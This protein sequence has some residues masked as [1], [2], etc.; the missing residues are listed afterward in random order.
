MREE[1]MTSAWIRLHRY[2]LFVFFGVGLGCGSPPSSLSSSPTGGVTA[3]RSALTSEVVV[4]LLDGWGDPIADHPIDALDENGGSVDTAVTDGNGQV[5]FFVEEP[6]TYYFRAVYQGAYFDSAACAAPS[7]ASSTVQIMKPV[8]VSVT[9]GYGAAIAD[10]NIT[11]I[12]SEGNQ[13][14]WLTT[15]S[16]GVA[17]VYVPSGAYFFRVVAGNMY[18]DSAATASCEIPGCVSASIAVTSVRVTVT[19]TDGKPAEGVTVAAVD[20]FE[21]NWSATDAQGRA[22]TFVPAGAFKFRVVANGEYYESGPDGHCVVSGCQS[23]SISVPACT[24]RPDGTT[25]NDGA[26]CTQSE[27]CHAGSCQ[28]SSAAPPILN[29]A[30]EH[31]GQMGGNFAIPSDVNA[32]GQTVGGATTASGQSHAFSRNPGGPMVDLGSQ[33]GLP[34]P[35][36][37]N[38]INDA[39]TVVG[40]MTQPDGSH[41]FRYNPSTGLEDLGLGGD[42]SSFTD[43][44]VYEGSYGRDVNGQGQVAGDYTDGGMLRGFRYTDGVGFEDIGSLDVGMT[45]AW[46][47]GNSGTVVGTSW[48]PGTPATNDVRRFGHAVLFQD[49]IS[50]LVD[51]NGLIDPLAGWTLH[52]AIDIAGDFVVG[53]G[54]RN[55]VLR[56]FRL[57]L[58]TG[59][60][61]DI[62]AGWEGRSFGNGVNI[63][64]DVVGWGYRDAAEAQQ[65]GF[66]YSDRF[67]FKNLND[68]INAN[69]WDVRTTSAI[70]NAGDIVGW[71]YLAGNVSAFHVR[72]PQGQAATCQARDVCGGGDGDTICLYSDGVVETSPGHFVAVLGFD[73]SSAASV[74][75]TVN[76]VRLDG[77]LV[78]NPQPAPPPFLLPGTHAGAFLPT[79]ETG[80]TISW[81]INGETVSASAASPRLQPVALPGGGVGV[82]IGGETID[83]AA[84]PQDAVTPRLDGICQLTAGQY[85]AVF[86]YDNIASQNVRLQHGTADNIV[87]VGDVVSANPTPAP[88]SWFLPGTHLGAFLPTFSSGQSVTWT[89]GGT[90]LTA[91]ATSTLLT[92]QRPV[93]GSNALI[94]T[95]QTPDGPTAVWIR[96][97]VP[98]QL[99][100]AIVGPDPTTPGATVGTLDGQLNVS[101]DGAA[102]YHVPIWVPDAPLVPNLALDYNSRNDE[103]FTGVGFSLTG[104]GEITRCRAAYA[105]DPPLRPESGVNFTDTDHLCLDGRILIPTSGTPWT[106]GAKFRPDNDPFTQVDQ[107]GSGEISY[108]EVSRR[109]GTIETYGQ[110]TDSVAGV[111]PAGIPRF[112]WGLNRRV[113]RSGNLVEYKYF[114]PTPAA[115]AIADRAPEGV[116]FGARSGQTQPYTVAFSYEAAANRGGYLSGYAR[117][118][119]RLLN[120]ITVS[121]PTLTTGGRSNDRVYKIAYDTPS[122][123]G[124]KLIKTIQ[125]CDNRDVSVATCMPPTTFTW[126]H[127][128]MRF[129][130]VGVSFGPGI[131]PLGSFAQHYYLLV[132]GDVN[133]DG[134]DDI[135][136]RGLGGFDDPPSATANQVVVYYR[137]SDG[138]GFGPVQMVPESAITPGDAWPTYARESLLFKDVLIA[139]VDMDGAADIKVGEDQRFR[140]ITGN[141]SVAAGDGAADFNGDGLPDYMNANSA[142]QYQNEQPVPNVPISVVPN[143]MFGAGT[144]PASYTFYGYGAFPPVGD[145]DG[146]GSVDLVLPMGH[147]AGVGLP[148]GV[149]TGL[150]DHPHGGAK[151]TVLVDVN[152]DGLPDALAFYESRAQL[153]AG[154]DNENP[155]LNINT[156]FRTGGGGFIPG[157]GLSRPDSGYITW[158]RTIDQNECVSFLPTG[159]HCNEPYRIIGTDPGLRVADF[160]GD[161]RE[162]IISFA[163]NFDSGVNGGIYQSTEAGSTNYSDTPA[164]L[165]IARGNSFIAQGPTTDTGR[166][167]L[168]GAPMGRGVGAN[169]FNR[170]LD[171]NGDGLPDLISRQRNSSLGL[172]L[173][174]HEGKKPD[175]LTSVTNGLGAT[176]EI[177]YDHLGNKE[178]GVYTRMPPGSCAYPQYCVTKGVWV[179]SKLR[180]DTGGAVGGTVFADTTFKYRDARTDVQGLGWIGFASMETTDQVTGKITDTTYGDAFIRFTAGGVSSYPRALLPTNVIETWPLDATQALRRTHDRAYTVGPAGEVLLA[181]S[182]E[183]EQELTSSGYATKT[184]RTLLRPEPDAYDAYGNPLHETER[185]EQSDSPQT[186]LHDV[187]LRTT[188]WTYDNDAQSW[189]LGLKRTETTTLQTFGADAE[190]VVRRLAWDYKP[191]T[192]LIAHGMREPNGAADVRLTTTFE[193]NSR[194]LVTRVIREDASGQR[195]VTDIGYD[196]FVGHLAETATQAG[197]TITQRRHPT[198]GVLVRAEDPNGAGASFVYD[199]FGRPKK[200]L[201]DAAGT[202]TLTYSPV[203]AGAGTFSIH[204]ATDGAPIRRTTFDELERARISLV[205]GL[206]SSTY[207][208]VFTDYDAAGRVARVSR[209]TDPAP[210]APTEAWK[211]TNFAY[212]AASRPT[213]T[214]YPAESVDTGGVPRTP[215]QVIRTYDWLSA[216]EFHL[217]KVGDTTARLIRTTTFD[218]R[219]DVVSTA[220]T[221]PDG[222]THIATT[223]FVY[224]AGGA[225]KKVTDAAGSVTT[226]VHD[227]WGR[228]TTLVDPD[229]GTTLTA[230]NA[231]DE[232]VS[233]TTARGTTIHTPDE[234]GRLIRDNGPD[235]I[236]T[237]IWDVEPKGLGKPGLAVSPDQVS[238][239]WAYDTASRVRATTWTVPGQPAPLTVT[240]NRDPFGRLQS[241]VYP[242]SGAYNLTAVYDYSPTGYLA[243]VTRQE[244]AASSL[245]WAVNARDFAGRITLE[246]FGGGAVAQTQTSRSYTLTGKL[247]GQGTTS[248]SP[249]S[250][251]HV[252][253]Y[254]YDGLGRLKTRAGD[255][256]QYDF[257]NRL[258]VWNHASSAW[259]ETYDYDD[260]GNLTRR[261]GAGPG[262]VEVDDPFTFTG[263]GGGPHAVKTGPDG[264]YAYDELGN[265]TTAPGRTAQFWEFG[266]PRQITSSGTT[267]TFKYDALHDR[268]LKS[269][270]QGSSTIS[271]G[272]LYE[273]RVT[274]S[275]TTYAYYVV[276]ERGVV[277][278]IEIDGLGNPHVNGLHDDHLGSAVLV[279]NETG[280]PSTI[281]FDPWGRKVTYDSNG[282]PIGVNMSV[283][284]LRIGFTGH[285]EDD[286]LGLVN[287][288]GRLYD[289]K[290][291]RFIS[292]DPFVSDPF[293]GQSHNRYA[294]VLN[295]PLN[296]IDPSGFQSQSAP[297]TSVPLPVQQTGGPACGGGCQAPSGSYVV[298]GGPTPAP[299]PT[300]STPTPVKG[301]AGGRPPPAP[302]APPSDSVGSYSGGGY[303]PGAAGPSRSAPSVTVTNLGTIVVP[304]T[305]PTPEQ[306]VSPVRA[307]ASAGVGFIP[308]L[309]VLQSFLELLSGEDIF[310][311]EPASRPLAA[312]AVIASIIPGGKGLVKALSKADDVV[313]ATR[314]RTIIGRFN[315]A[316]AEI[317]GIRAGEN[318]LLKHLPNQG[319]PKANWAQNASVLRQEMSKGLPIRDAAVDP[320]TGQLIDYPGRFINAERNLLRDHGWTYNHAS[321]LWSPP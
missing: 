98:A 252:A 277:A 152:G 105:Q 189:L 258:R 14:A 160:N 118:S 278:Q 153:P 208:A 197:L 166:T 263:P 180:R 223:A 206:Q 67:G 163:S 50:G 270:N 200:V 161:G 305:L 248:L 262:G 204:E 48:V 27:I 283:A 264:A 316:T 100:S 265:Q 167:I 286:E 122:I 79:F 318:S 147:A 210:S 111:G 63:H 41:A 287:M 49:S 107:I 55:G 310:T 4:S 195:R 12:D 149:S 121:G 92:C 133:G 236:S 83:L 288:R 36:G 56:A 191:G 108:F 281:D 124:R 170:V 45:H 205:Q 196:S 213:T 72:M 247:F 314:G 233:D 114:A 23:A 321:M 289:P 235:G 29:L 8:E 102:T 207:S 312:I 76:E 234:L 271:I 71:G 202:T 185:I 303:S 120:Q 113:D 84:S 244:G 81:T 131:A 256:F 150:P 58:S 320:V 216:T 47:I 172:H 70:N 212:D 26:I 199:S 249:P 307:L 243:S 146:N 2:V 22:D 96:R 285:D 116:K 230:Y 250:S 20:G 62:S 183:K 304:R 40:Q 173:Y 209:P 65:A 132:T 164:V 215:G 143:T 241:V 6:A 294:Y 97:D 174:I 74:Q 128:T 145:I 125:Q 59:I 224:G 138:S 253:A 51:L 261:R 291:R 19:G 176:D 139:D 302:V 156:G 15:D 242:P 276:G 190:T 231:F 119:T 255:T 38:A 21:V 279:T 239:R 259:T 18:F 267:T 80:Q 178:S 104:F 87:T 78:A 298:P 66:V 109:D 54:E 134:L 94:A 13:A 181:S 103:S 148:S 5:S 101:N 112:S 33:L 188:D 34:A 177:E 151:P 192:N 64:G 158:L 257:L 31:L 130:D 175:L 268:V 35:N 169:V 46:G 30:V 9:N 123:S 308:Y 293:N 251:L 301:T 154:V 254:D 75:P 142:R 157:G 297:G 115:N 69:G 313:D 237:T 82:V 137:L 60:V 296:L 162:D 28:A 171:V 32:S 86:G 53:T 168:G 315:P 135:I 3:R 266:L 165:L 141:T 17:A 136:Y 44:A 319:S 127:G 52:Q 238:T 317:E 273:K 194:G 290:Q 85:L 240:R 282:R 144:G 220:S 225:L 68:V 73:N 88:P 193:R 99:E 222:P 43:F 292:P 245:L 95:V 129:K 39:G 11:A 42:G 274:S 159:S 227:A 299:Q 93:P 260:I 228:R 7:C 269:N 280:E 91:D 246:T 90:T 1:P 77:N 217:D 229:T 201:P 57:R 25:C 179:V 106:N 311:G 309:G 10:Q 300:P 16:A 306:N 37:A 218:A 226:T 110:T 126:E 272:G 219:G 186:S 295:N 184:Q 155:T 275:D 232:A 117:P 187:F 211:Y 214:T 203:F 140:S 24:G 221:D 198:F 284:G 89:V 61:D 182:V